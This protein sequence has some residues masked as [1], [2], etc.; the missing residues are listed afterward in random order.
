MTSFLN[1]SLDTKL[2]KKLVI[3][4]TVF[5]IFWILGL[6]IFLFRADEFLGNKLN[7]DWVGLVSVIPFIYI[8]AFFIV[9]RRYKWYYWLAYFA[10]PLLIFFWFIPKLVLNK[11]KIYL[12]LQY[13]ILALKSLKDIKTNAILLAIF[14]GTIVLLANVHNYYIAISVMLFYAFLYL[15]LM[16]NFVSVFLPAKLFSIGLQK[17]AENFS[18]K[19]DIYG[20]AFIESLEKNKEDEKLTKEQN[21]LK[22]IERLVIA[23]FVLSHIKDALNSFKHKRALVISFFFQFITMFVLTLV[24]FTVI[25]KLLYGIQPA[26]YFVTSAPTTFDFFYYTFKNITFS[27]IDSLKP[28]TVLAKCIEIASFVIIYLFLI[29]I[30]L[31]MVFSFGQESVKENISSIV[32]ACDD[33]NNVIADYVQRKYNIQITKVVTEVDS[34]Q[35]SLNSIKSIINSFF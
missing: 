28:A 4:H 18:Q 25:N 16:K 23:K 13:G 30:V 31:S 7:K 14:F 32:I 3:L 15:K 35:K 21:E 9:F 24:L 8:L 34:I 19:N 1:T 20:S 17:I 12:F 22:R 33:Q 29:I 27:N 6:A 2:P 11:G 5:C 10:Y 26:S